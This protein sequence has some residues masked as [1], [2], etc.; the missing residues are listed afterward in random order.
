MC[1]SSICFLTPAGFPV[2]GAAQSSGEDW[3]QFQGGHVT[4]SVS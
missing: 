3:P 2:A 1:R 4:V